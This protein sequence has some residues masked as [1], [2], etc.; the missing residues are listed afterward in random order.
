MLSGSS[1]FQGSID[2]LKTIG[3][4][5]QYVL[6]DGTYNIYYVYIGRDK[7][8]NLREIAQEFG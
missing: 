6:K 7:V 5:Y 1:L 3:I 2:I 8:Y 4:D